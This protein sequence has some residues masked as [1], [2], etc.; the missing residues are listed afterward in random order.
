M[1]D[2]EQSYT[3]QQAPIRRVWRTSPRGMDSL[4]TT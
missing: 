4:P 1:S 2:E 3:A